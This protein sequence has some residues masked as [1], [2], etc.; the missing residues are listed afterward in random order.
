M[1]RI[2]SSGYR[3][4][5]HGLAESSLFKAFRVHRWVLWW[6][7][8]GVVCGIVAIANILF[9]DLTQTQERALIFFGIMH[10]LLGGLVCWACKG[11]RTEKPMQPPVEKQPESVA[12]EEEW[13]AA[14]DFLFPG[15][16]HT[17]LP[18]S[19]T[20]QSREM[21]DVYMLRHVEHKPQSRS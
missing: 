21:L 19:R 9:R 4:S 10:W 18:P 6:F 2:I 12:Q 16:G 20:Q 15:G 5:R 13:H 1:R 7:Y 3:E 11:I 8:V 14:S 17:V